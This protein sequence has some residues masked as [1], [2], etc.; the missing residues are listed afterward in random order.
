MLT[1]DYF[2]CRLTNKP[3]LFQVDRH[4]KYETFTQPINDGDL[5]L[6]TQP[7]R[8]GFEFRFCA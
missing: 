2:L 6:T 1:P 7:A 8:Q 5:L 4:G 3:K